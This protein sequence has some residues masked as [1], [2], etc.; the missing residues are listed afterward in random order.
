[1]SDMKKSGI[2]AAAVLAL[3]LPNFAMADS[4]HEPSIFGDDADGAHISVQLDEDVA[5]DA[6]DEDNTG[7]GVGDENDIA[8]SEDT[9][10]TAT[11][12]GDGPIYVEFASGS[13]PVQ[14]DDE[15]VTAQPG[16]GN[17]AQLSDVADR[18]DPTLGINVRDKVA[19][20][21]QCAILLDSRQTYQIFFKLYCD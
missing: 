17:S 21:A 16:L 3:S 13:G 12:D 20:S 6:S 11:D 19:V 8:E 15:P 18:F 5:E 7:L 9:S 2:V 1:M 10:V 14:H 4:L